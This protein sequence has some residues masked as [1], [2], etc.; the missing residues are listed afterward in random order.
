MNAVLPSVIIF[1]LDIL[2]AIILSVILSSVMALNLNLPS[3]TRHFYE[4]NFK[5]SL[6]KILWQL[7]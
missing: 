5:S 3:R 4:Q 2:S 1:T 7:K 6:K